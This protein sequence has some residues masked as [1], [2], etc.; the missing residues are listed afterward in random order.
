MIFGL[1]ILV[2]GGALVSIL[3]SGQLSPIRR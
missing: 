1:M 3:M 2:G